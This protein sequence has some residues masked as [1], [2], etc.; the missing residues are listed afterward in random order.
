[1]CAY[2]VHNSLHKS[3]L[4]AGQGPVVKL[5]LTIRREV[6]SVV[7]PAKAVSRVVNGSPAR[8][9][10][11][12]GERVNPRPRALRSVLTPR[13]LPSVSLGSSTEIAERGVESPVLIW[14]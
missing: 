12:A 14:E 3:I 13:W 8:V 9:L 5:D 2:T 1:M 4:G 11:R 7:K 10:G 6:A